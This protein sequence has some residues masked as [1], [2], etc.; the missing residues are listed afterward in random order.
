MSVDTWRQK[1]KLLRTLPKPQC[2]TMPV[3]V[4]SHQR[5]GSSIR[6]SQTKMLI[7]RDASTQ[8]IAKLK[9]YH[10]EL[11]QDTGV[12]EC[13]DT[14]GDFFNPAVP[15]NVRFEKYVKDMKKR[16]STTPT[17]SRK[18][19]ITPVVTSKSLDY[20]SDLKCGRW[21]VLPSI[22]TKARLLDLST[23]LSVS[24]VGVNT[25]WSMN[26]SKRN[27]SQYTG[28]VIVSGWKTAR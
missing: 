14:L 13:L 22:S 1:L 10:R 7:Q 16:G 12:P 25:E 17:V 5:S 8:T 2:Q 27:S 21:S 9:L 15:A 23:K 28:T 6:K 20:H 26:V 19:H 11:P 4:P 18:G 24:T 3:P